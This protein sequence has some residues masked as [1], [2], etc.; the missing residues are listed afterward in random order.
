MKVLVVTNMYPDPEMPYFGT[1]VKQQVDSLIEEGVDVDVLLINGEKNTINYFWGF[2]RFWARILT[3]RYDLVHAHYVFSGIIARAQF[4]L[5]V[6]LTHHGSQVFYSWQAPVCRMISRFVDRT[7]VMSREMKERGKLEK[8]TVIPC[9]IDFKLFKPMPI[10]QVRNELNLPEDKKLVMFAGEYHKRVK[11]YDIV[12]ESVKILQQD[13]PE[14]EL[15]LVTKK[16]LDVVPKYM[17]A[18]DAFVLVSNGEGSPMVIKESMACNL[19]I[20]SVPVGD[21]PEVIEGTDGCYICSQDPKDVAEKLKLA[22]NRKE[23]TNGRERISYLEIG[24]I[25]RKIIKIYEEV[26]EKKKNRWWKFK[27][28][29]RNNRRKNKEIG[30]PAS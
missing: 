14:V 27:W 22:I 11:R 28:I 5:P 17:N 21:V 29:S 3:R 30:Y 8:S 16:P 15:V 4:I 23:R 1:F 20:V 2:L 24:E 6:V 9:G 18:C 26:I 19:P 13:T 10:N 12:E 25:S 7:I